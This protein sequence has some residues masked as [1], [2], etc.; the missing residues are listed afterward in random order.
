MATTPHSNQSQST[1]HRH[2]VVLSAQVHNSVFSIAVS[3]GEIN[4]RWPPKLTLV[5]GVVSALLWLLPGDARAVNKCTGVDGRIVTQEAPCPPDPSAKELAK[6]FVDQNRSPMDRLAALQKLRAI[7]PV[8]ADKFEP[9]RQ[10]LLPLATKQSEDALRRIDSAN[11][12]MGIKVGMSAAEVLGAKY[13]GKPTRINHTTG[14]N[15]TRE[16]WVYGDGRY[17]YLDRGIVTAIQH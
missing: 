10:K 3:I 9:T 2:Q 7:D 14:A 15:G 8:L 12:V 13:W 11:S 17:V 4:V 1:P 5:A 16:Q 6:Q